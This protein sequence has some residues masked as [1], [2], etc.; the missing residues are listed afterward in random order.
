MIIAEFHA[1]NFKNIR[2]VDI[3]PD[4]D[5]PTV[6]LS[7]PNAAGKSSILDAIEA[8]IAG[9]KATKTRRP[10]RDGEDHAEVRIQ[11]GQFDV[12]RTW[13]RKGDG[14]DFE[15]KMILKQ[16]A[17]E[18]DEQGQPRWSHVARPQELLDRFWSALAMDP[19]AFLEL[20]PKQQQAE[21]VGLVSLPFD[22]IKL[23]EDR[24]RAYESRTEAGRTLKQL[25]GEVAGYAKPPADLPAA[26]TSAVELFDKLTALEA[27]TRERATAEHAV[28]NRLLNLEGFREQI[29][30]LEATIVEFETELDVEQG[31]LDRR[32][33]VDVRVVDGIREQIAKLDGTNAAVRA[34]QSRQAAITRRDAA[35]EKVAE[36]AQQIQDY[37]DQRAQ[38]LAAAKFPVDGLGFDA[39]GVTYL[40]L[41]LSDAS[42][43]EQWESAFA[44]AATANP[45]L[46]VFRINQ[47]S[48]IDAA[49][50]KTIESLARKHDAQVWIEV[51]DESGAV[52]VVINEG[53]VVAQNGSK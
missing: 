4:P 26:E 46:R 8:A 30:R 14:D 42:T 31:E 5:N 24:A 7:G 6:L 41:P 51:V 29:A 47:G 37:D 45:G 48:L 17:A 50:M 43:A 10:I 9:G 52:G 23:D 38:G 3:T 16:L 27:Q 1:E 11:F 20:T 40:G 22:P 44:I 28:K 34:E 53:R 18:P 2:V 15:T 19:L 49:H 13:D 36:L 25:E 12:L 21:L 33:P 32:P 35:A 39:N